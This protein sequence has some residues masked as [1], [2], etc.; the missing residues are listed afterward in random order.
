MSGWLVGAP[1]L[2]AVTMVL[3]SPRLARR[4]RPG[5]ATIVLTGLAV[6]IALTCG[7]VL[8]AAAT[9]SLAQIDV[10]ARAGGWTSNVLAQRGAAPLW[11][12]LVLA[13]LV[14]VL[15]VRAGW[16]LV[17]LLRALRRARGDLPGG[18]YP[19]VVVDYET[20]TAYAVAGRR[21]RIVMTTGLVRA[22]T[23]RERQVVL[24]H[25]GAHLRHR[26]FLFVAIAEVS[27]AANPFLHSTA[28]AVRETVERW[29][30]ET[31][32]RDVG[33][34]EVVAHAIARVALLS[35]RRNNSAG[36]LGV[37]RGDVVQRVEAMLAPRQKTS[38]W[39]G[40]AVAAA[41]AATWAATIGYATYTHD[42]IELAERVYSR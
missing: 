1:F 6:S 13:G 4:V 14:V 24:A 22:L 17:A 5:F 30:D 27:A 7:L 15:V 33:D 32:A 25:E 10:A 41:T 12:G 16:R 35:G 18:D 31:A 36:V 19:L 28:G 23:S 21:G 20:P 34:R 37:G 38:R 3:V 40:A 2:L 39:I 9:L 26:H 11:L 42:I 8:S 29:A